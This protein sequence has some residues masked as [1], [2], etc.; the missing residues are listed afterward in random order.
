MLEFAAHC[1]FRFVRAH[2]DT[3][4][5]VYTAVGVYLGMIV[6][7]PDGFR[8]TVS[9][10]RGAAGALVNIE[11]NRVSV[12]IQCITPL[13]VEV[14]AHGNNR[15]LTHFRINGHF[16]RVTLHIGKSHTCAETECSDIFVGG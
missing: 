16:V 7:Y 14:H 9:R 13:F 6:N 5:A 10:A 15:T 1:F 12:R 11:H 4:T 2:S 8:G 3:F